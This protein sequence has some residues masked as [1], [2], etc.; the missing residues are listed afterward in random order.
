MD[1]RTASIALRLSKGACTRAFGVEVGAGSGGKVLLRYR[2]DHGVTCSHE[3]AVFSS[4]SNWVYRK[5][6]GNGAVSTYHQTHRELCPN[7]WV[8]SEISLASAPLLQDLGP[9][10]L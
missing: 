5:L 8:M 2:L 10:T 1:P 7:P 9:P 3:V 6:L 4:V